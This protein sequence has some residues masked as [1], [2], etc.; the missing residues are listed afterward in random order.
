MTH[1]QN[2]HIQKWMETDHQ[3]IKSYSECIVVLDPNGVILSINEKTLAILLEDRFKCDELV[4]CSYKVLETDETREFIRCLCNSPIGESDVPWNDRI[5]LVKK[6]H[7]FDEQ[8]TL[9][10]I[11]FCLQ[12]VTV[13]RKA[14]ERTRQSEKFAVVGQLSAGLAHELLNPLTVIKGYLQLYEK[15]Q[16]VRSDSWSLL[17]QE[18]E[19]V[20]SLVNDFLL[21]TNPSAPKYERFNLAETLADVVA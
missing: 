17:L 4:G 14:E 8:N 19:K 10:G 11:T 20:E 6:S 13:Q 16:V 5:W 21:L 1:M 2:L 12:D 3:L 15:N 9:L 18:V 7:L